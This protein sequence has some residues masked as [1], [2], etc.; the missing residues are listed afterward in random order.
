MRAMIAAAAADG[1]VDAAE[2]KKILS[3]FGKGDLDAD[4]RQFFARE[5]E[6]PATVD[7]LAEACSSP[8][9]GV[10]VYT[11]ARLAVD[12]DSDE[13]HEFLAA[14][15]EPARHRRQPRRAYRRRRA[16]RALRSARR[17]STA[18]RRSAGRGMP[19]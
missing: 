2:Q 15:A 3:G 10:K 4:A 18:S 9:E 5:L 17:G 14:L 7:E 13:E 16:Q 11:A 1:R 6:K 19:R 12:V 8:E